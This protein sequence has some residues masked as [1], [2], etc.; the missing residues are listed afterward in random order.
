MSITVSRPKKS[1][2]TPQIFVQT[3][4]QDTVYV[5]RHQHDHDHSP[6]RNS[7]GNLSKRLLSA[8]SRPNGLRLVKEIES[9]SPL[10]REESNVSLGENRLGDVSEPLSVDM[11]IKVQ[12]VGHVELE[13][14]GDKEIGGKHK[15]FPTTSTQIFSI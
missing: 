12:R 4:H 6:D 13:E 7:V 10:A 1:P 14:V 15:Y 8:R 11:G 3:T 2:N 9:H 5:V